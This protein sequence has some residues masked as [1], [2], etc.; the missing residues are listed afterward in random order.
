MYRRWKTH[1]HRWTCKCALCHINTHLL[2]TRADWML[3]PPPSTPLQG[4]T[5]TGSQ[6]CGPIRGRPGVALEGCWVVLIDLGTNVIT[7]LHLCVKLLA[8]NKWMTCGVDDLQKKL[9]QSGD[10]KF[11]QRCW[12]DTHSLDT[13]FIS[14]LNIKKWNANL[15]Y[16]NSKLYLSSL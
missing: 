14:L 9:I 4:R 3:N 12:F 8:W 13:G 15:N 6:L 7:A 10:N 2:R 1:H 11:C 5:L 16:S